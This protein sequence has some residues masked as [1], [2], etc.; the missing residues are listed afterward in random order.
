MRFFAWSFWLSKQGKVGIRQE[1]GAVVADQNIV[2]I[3]FKG[4]DNGVVQQ[5]FPAPIGGAY[6]GG[7]EHAVFYRNNAGVLAFPGDLLSGDQTEIDVVTFSCQ[8]EG[9]GGNLQK[10]ALLGGTMSASL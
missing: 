8:G 9:D 2:E 6:A 5:H 1:I 10:Q 3:L 7:G 4:K